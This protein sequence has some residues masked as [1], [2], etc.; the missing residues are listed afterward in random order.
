M[1]EREFDRPPDFSNPTYQDQR[2]DSGNLNHHDYDAI[3]S[4]LLE[5]GHICSFSD[6][7]KQMLKD[8]AT[9]GKVMK[10]AFIYMFVGLALLAVL[11]ETAL[12]KVTSFFGGIFK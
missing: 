9:G 3:R 2:Q 10:R 12:R 4:M 5:H 7:E 11:S 8:M 6:E 1:A